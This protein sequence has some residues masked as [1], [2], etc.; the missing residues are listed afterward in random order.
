M[1]AFNVRTAL[2]YLL[3]YGSTVC[4]SVRSISVLILVPIFICM[5]NFYLF[6][7]FV[8][9]VSR[10]LE[11]KLLCWNVRK[12]TFICLKNRLDSSSMLHPLPSLSYNQNFSFSHHMASLTP[13]TFP[14]NLHNVGVLC[15]FSIIWWVRREFSSHWKRLDLLLILPNAT[16]HLK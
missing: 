15:R 6:S 7:F 14:V 12:V 5:L 16:T 4:L 3:L 2:S 1:I 9:Q 8:F 11:K 10:W 13:L